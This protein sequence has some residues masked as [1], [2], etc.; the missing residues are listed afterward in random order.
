MLNVTL[1]YYTL[2]LKELVC[3]PIRP[4]KRN[5]SSN[6]DVTSSTSTKLNKQSAVLLSTFK[7]NS[8][9]TYTLNKHLDFLSLGIHYL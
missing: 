3:Y 5:T 9:V 2:S 7:Q 8:L 6:F 1:S 4:R